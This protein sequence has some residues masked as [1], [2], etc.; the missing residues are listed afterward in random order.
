MHW[1]SAQ[2]P[3]FRH[4]ADL[5]NIAR[6]WIYQTGRSYT[7]C[8]K[9]SSSTIGGLGLPSSQMSVFTSSHCQESATGCMN[10]CS[11]DGPNPSPSA[12]IMPMKV[13]Q[14]PSVTSSLAPWIPFEIMDMSQ[15]PVPLIR[16]ERAPAGRAKGEQD[17]TESSTARYACVIA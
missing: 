9:D 15:V 7:H 11:V 16:C 4:L 13:L 3:C 17:R 6:S 14:P 5:K 12:L 2:C 8:L 10:E 1:T